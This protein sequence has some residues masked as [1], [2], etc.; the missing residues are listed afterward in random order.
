MQHYDGGVKP[1][2]L[3]IAAAAVAMTMLGATVAH[4]TPPP[5][6][7]HL[8]RINQQSGPLDGDASL[9]P[10]TGAGVTIYVVDSGTRLSH[11]QFGGRALAGADPVTTSGQAPIEPRSSDCDGHGTHVAALAAGQ[12]VGVAPG[13]TVVSVR[14]LDCEGQG[15]VENVVKGLQWIRSH[16]VSGRA[17]VVNLSLA[18][19]RYD[20]GEEIDA[21]VKAMIAE[22]M[23]VTI[24]AGNGEKDID[25]ENQPF[26]ACLISPGH[27]P[28]A[29]TVAASTA[30]DRPASYSNFGPCVDLFAPGGNSANPMVS[31]W[32]GN[33]VNDG[34]DATRA[35]GNT[36]DDAWYMAN[37]G[38]SMAS[39]L[40]AGY[41]ALLA[42]Q[43]PGLCGTQIHD[44]IVQ[45]ATPN[46]LAG[47]DATTANRLLYVDTT[48]IPASVPG[49][50]SSVI[51]TV[52]N[53]SVVATWDPPCDGGSALTKTTVTLYEGSRVVQRKTVGPG[54][55]AARFTGLKNGTRYRV[56]LQHHNAVGDGAA[57]TRWRTVTVRQLRPGQTVAV[58]SIGAFGGDLT[59]RWKVASSSGSVCKLLTKPTRLR[60]TRR[61]T[62]RVELRTRA[63]GEPVFHNIRVG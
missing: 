59:L 33:D 4:A 37:Q 61:G 50:A 35:A 63:G 58:S 60:F 1:R 55:T 19:D 13:A 27:V 15:T 32:F 25:G 46:M 39:P 20:N 10:L 2:G 21:Q 14:V 29:I 9:G 12:T 8:D 54:T 51:T 30:A 36:S 23:V 44:A 7:W 38:T 26:D 6:P 43:Q 52:S 41:A 45:R 18:V 57:T 28:S 42:Q 56:R 48:P 40:V 47:V 22:G 5:A 3:S 34:V 17:A 16:H 53:R 11:E 49:R 62:C 24:A 31:A